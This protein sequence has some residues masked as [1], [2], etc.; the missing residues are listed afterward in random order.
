M[1]VQLNDNPQRLIAP[2]S[3]ASKL[4]FICGNSSSFESRVRI[5]FPQKQRAVIQWALRSGQSAW[6]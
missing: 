6:G 1:K 3:F 2:K 5:T 4:T